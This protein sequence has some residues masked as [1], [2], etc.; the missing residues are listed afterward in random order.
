MQSRTA[1][2]RL[3]GSAGFAVSVFSLA[4]CAPAQ[5][6]PAPTPRPQLDVVPEAELGERLY[7]ER[8]S[9]CHDA[10]RAPPRSQI[11]ANSPQQILEA[12]DT[13]FMASVAMFMSAEEKAVLV[14]HL[15]ASAAP[16]SGAERDFP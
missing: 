4:A 12:L 11:A 3:V 16:P 5:V 15:S 6:A 7:L 1:L 10:G 13:G 9:S 14:R 2:L 8:C